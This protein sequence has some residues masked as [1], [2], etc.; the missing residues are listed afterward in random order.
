MAVGLADFLV[1]ESNV[2][3]FGLVLEDE[4]VSEQLRVVRTFLYILCEASVWCEGRG[5]DCVSK[6]HLT[7]HEEFLSLCH[8]PVAYCM[9]NRLELPSNSITYSPPLLLFFFP[10]SL[11]LPRLSPPPLSPY[12]TSLLPLSLPCLSPPPL[13]PYLTSLLPLSPYLTSF[14]PP[15]LSLP[16]F[17]P[18]SPL[19]LPLPPSFSLPHFSPSLSLPHFSLSHLPL[20]D[21]IVEVCGE[22]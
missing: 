2:H 17:S 16:H 3:W 5:D 1:P 22:L 19:T 18:P 10:P 15:S 12:L 13:S 8:C 20:G 7:S 21:K 14:L 4:R 11:S 6:P 9:H